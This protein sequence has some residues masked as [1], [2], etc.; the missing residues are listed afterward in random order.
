M[1][2]ISLNKNL[3]EINNL[4]LA[5][6]NF[7]G[8]HKGHQEL[9]KL[10]KDIAIKENGKFGILT[11][12][13]HPIS[14][15]IPERKNY[16]ITPLEIKKNIL[17]ELKV[18]NLFLIDFDSSFSEITAED[19]IKK[20]LVDKLKV[21]TVI[22]GKDFVFGK[23]RLGNFETLTN[24]SEQYNFRYISSD[25]LFI[26]EK[27]KFSSTEIRK[28]LHEGNIELANSHLGRN[29][30]ISGTVVG[31]RQE[32]RKLGFKTANINF[33]E[34]V[35]PKFGVYSCN[36]KF[37]GDLYKA[38][39]NIGVRPTFDL[40]KPILEVHIFNF[41]RDIYKKYVEVEFIEFI[42]EEKK[43]NSVEELKG[44]IQDDI[45]RVHNS[46]DMLAN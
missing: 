17:S 41:D 8:V 14:Y 20:I 28:S 40:N 39:A 1:D 13:P 37:D 21:S 30:I 45:K 29:Y 25:L 38:I 18:D 9:I 12:E 6:G 5:I 27:A 36:I 22:T 11:F 19:F 2:V 35:I 10:G 3:P 46:F 15:F 24:A 7:D 34:F 16:R 32:G 31:G 4:T 43:F 26:D 33:E 42:R 44:Q 23:D